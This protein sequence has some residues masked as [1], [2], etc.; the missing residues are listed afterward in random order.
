MCGGRLRSVL[1]NRNEASQLYKKRLLLRKSITKV[2]L[3][4]HKVRIHNR[5]KM[6]CSDGNYDTSRCQLLPFGYVEILSYWGADVKIYCQFFNKVALSL[7]IHGW[8]DCLLDFLWVF[9][10]LSHPPIP[11]RQ[12][13]ATASGY[14]TRK[15]AYYT[16]KLPS[17]VV[18]TGIAGRL[19]PHIPISALN[20]NSFGYQI[21]KYTKNTHE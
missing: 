14:K 1:Y 21:W 8:I 19:M 6:D 4:A 5:G 10:L 11:T 3:L 20:S 15:Q 17:A 7:A 2:L 13:S 16:R 12:D 18:I 9:F